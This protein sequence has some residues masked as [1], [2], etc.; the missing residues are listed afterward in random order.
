MSYALINFLSN[1]NSVTGT[2]QAVNTV[3]SGDAA[4]VVA[5]VGKIVS[6]F[7]I[8]IPII[9]VVV[10][11]IALGKAVV[12][13]KDDEVKKATGGLVK[14]IIFAA[15]IFFVVAI[16]RLVV[17]IVST[18]TNNDMDT[19]WKIFADPWNTKYDAANL[20]K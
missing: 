12:S 6:I 14:K 13:G 10:G 2:N 20:G 7:Q 8:V 1:N 17:S 3:C 11:L 16:V 4:S 18:S 9:L 5:L 15:A 19:C